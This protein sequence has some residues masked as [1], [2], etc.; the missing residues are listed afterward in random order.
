LSDEH[1]D[2]KWVTPEDA[3][4]LAGH[5]ALKRYLKIQIQEKQLAKRIIFQEQQEGE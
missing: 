1:T 3:L 4:E 5:P 2:Y